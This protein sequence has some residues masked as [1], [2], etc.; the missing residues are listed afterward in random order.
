MNWKCLD[1]SDVNL[2]RSCPAVQVASSTS[3]ESGP[4][5]LCI[6]FTKVISDGILI[7]PHHP[8]KKLFLGLPLLQFSTYCMSSKVITVSID[9]ILSVKNVWVWVLMVLYT[10]NV[11]GIPANIYSVFQKINK[12]WNTKEK[13][14][15]WESFRSCLHSQSSPI[16][17]EICWIGCAF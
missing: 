4:T 7:L 2:N 15:S 10:A 3:Q 12:N 11:C 8:N 17:V 9:Q 14:K 6:L 16:L 1:L 5:T 13:L